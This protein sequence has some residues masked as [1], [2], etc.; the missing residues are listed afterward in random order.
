MDGPSSAACSATSV[1]HRSIGATDNCISRQSNWRSAACRLW[2]MKEA[3]YR[4]YLADRLIDS[5]VAPR[6]VT[7]ALGVDPAPPDGEGGVQFRRAAV[8]PGN[9]HPERRWDNGIWRDRGPGCRAKPGGRAGIPD[10]ATPTNSSTP[11]I[12]RFMRSPRGSASTKPGSW[13]WPLTRA[14]GSTLIIGRSTTRSARRTMVVP[15]CLPLD[16]RCGRLL[17]EEIRPCRSRRHQPRRLRPAAMGGEIQS[18]E[19]RWRTGVVET[20]ES[21]TRHLQNWK[22]RRSIL[23][24]VVGS[25]G[26]IYASAIALPCSADIPAASQHY[27]SS[28]YE[29]S[30]EV[31]KGLLACVSEATDDGVA[32]PLDDHSGCNSVTDHPPYATVFRNY[33]VATKVNTPDEL[34]RLYCRDRE[35]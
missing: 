11:F 2:P 10:R 34:A 9:R 25:V 31:P 13:D 26:A 1:A 6:E 27:D 21:V 18:S 30:A 20:I 29:F 28:E 14:A 16:C 5:G 35:A 19:S 33:N 24:R 15:M 12:R 17:G 23:M 8:P 7:K 4:L 22:S 3:S 32:I